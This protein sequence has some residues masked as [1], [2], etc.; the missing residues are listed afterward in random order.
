MHTQTHHTLSVKE[1]K[2]RLFYIRG[3]GEGGDEEG[4]GEEVTLNETYSG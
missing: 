2:A 1:K 4:E 3:V